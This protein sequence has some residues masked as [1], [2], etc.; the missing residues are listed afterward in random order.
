M[1]QNEGFF[2]G[3]MKKM[4]DIF[5]GSDRVAGIVAASAALV[6]LFMTFD[7]LPDTLPLFL[8]YLDDVAIM[9]LSYV[10]GRHIAHVILKK[11][12]MAK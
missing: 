8:G 6:Y 9:L 3:L 12:G 10:V 4:K 2:A 7:L 1:A 11:F 5:W